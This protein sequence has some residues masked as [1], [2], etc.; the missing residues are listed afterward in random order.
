MKRFFDLLLGLICA[1][2]FLLPVILISIIIRLTSEGPSL[3]WSNRVGID[4]RIFRMP[5]FRTM[6]IDTPS[7]ATHLLNKPESFYTPVGKFLRETSLDEIPQLW[8]III[9]DMSFVGPRP[10]LYNQDD[11]INLRDKKGIHKLQPGL[12]GWAQINGRDD[13][14][15]EKKVVFDEEYLS[16]ASFFFDMLIIV[17]TI[18]KIIKRSGI[19]H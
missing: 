11:L 18:F 5:K 6:R 2:A 12:T 14:S 15:I 9:G 8:S 17:R 19:S 7:K 13:L 4:K 1:T 3:Y 10:A 16:K